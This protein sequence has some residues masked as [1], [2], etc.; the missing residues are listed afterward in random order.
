MPAFVAGALPWPCR[1]GGLPSVR[2]PRGCGCHQGLH[3]AAADLP[4]DPGRGR[5]HGARC[6]HAGCSVGR[7]PECDRG[8]VSDVG[9]S[10]RPRVDQGPDRR[11]RPRQD[12][13]DEVAAAE[14]M[15][16]PR[17]RRSGCWSRC[18][19]RDASGNDQR[20][21]SPAGSRLRGPDSRLSLAD[22]GASGSAG[23][24]TGAL[25]PLFSRDA[26]DRQIS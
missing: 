25:A 2:L 19:G 13:G 6:N 17:P 22:P 5:R 24:A 1:N 26:H 16:T 21:V 3:S 11:S 12:R 10:G 15:G 4:G 23:N 7:L 20:H 14:W 8:A 9:P 18:G